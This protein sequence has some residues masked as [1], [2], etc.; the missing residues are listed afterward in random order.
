MDNCL[1]PPAL[2]VG[3]TGGTSLTQVR[4]SCLVNLD[5]VCHAVI[6]LDFE[7]ECSRAL[8]VQP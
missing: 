3:V 2:N 4:I 8:D 7:L 6:V 5:F 1:L